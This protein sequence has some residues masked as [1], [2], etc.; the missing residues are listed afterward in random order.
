VQAIVYST[1]SVRVA[2]NE[3]AV[4]DALASAEVRAVLRDYNRRAVQR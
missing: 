2:E 3:A 4:D 1:C